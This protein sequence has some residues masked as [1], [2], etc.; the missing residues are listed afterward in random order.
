MSNSQL[1]N[2]VGGTWVHSSASEY[3]DVILPL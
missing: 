2:Y 1:L 3:L